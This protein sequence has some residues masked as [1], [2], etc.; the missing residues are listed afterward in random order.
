MTAAMIT[1]AHALL[2]IIRPIPDYS[3]FDLMADGFEELKSLAIRQKLFML[4]YSR[5]KN[6]ADESAPGSPIKLFLKSNEAIYMTGVT[7]AMR[8]EALETEITGLLRDH[9][10]ES[11]VIK[12]NPLAGQIYECEYCRTSSDIDILIREGDICG[13]DAALTGSGYAREAG[14]PLEF[15]AE[16]LHHA[17]YYH[18][19]TGFVVEVHWNFCIPGFFAISSREIW[20]DV[21][22]DR[23][24]PAELSPEMTIIMLL[25]H[26]HMHF[27]RDLW[28]LVDLFHALNKYG[29][30]IN[31]EIFAQRLLRTGLVK[32]ALIA[33]GQMEYLWGDDG[34]DILQA[35]TLAFTLKKAGCRT[36]VLLLSYF[37]IDPVRKIES[38]DRM[39]RIISRI[40][41]DRPLVIIHSFIKTFMPPPAVVMKYYGDTRSLA[42]PYN[43]TRFIL[44]RIKAWL[45]GH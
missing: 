23:E 41:L 24:I 38:R 42:L 26:H 18:Q 33:I 39:D 31:N 25:M 16:R 43:Y 5:L 15:S 21:V 1:P 10:I 22:R 28:V 3:V 17:V 20:G 4:L 11:L 44:W 32:T 19:V 9:N 40:A 45:S 35:S 14:G 8:Q 29:K 7:R 37:R 36:P 2:G 27:F 12:G 6:A 30:V 13:A 34:P